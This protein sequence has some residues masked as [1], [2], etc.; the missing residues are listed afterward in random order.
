[1]PIPL[2][3]ILLL[4]SGRRGRFP[5]GRLA[6]LPVQAYLAR[7]LV[8]VQLRRRRARPPPR[9]TLLNRARQPLALHLTS[10]ISGGLMVHVPRARVRP[11]PSHPRA[12]RAPRS[13]PSPRPPCFGKIST[14]FS[15]DDLPLGNGMP[16]QPVGATAR[17][18]EGAGLPER[19]RIGRRVAKG[20][21][22][23]RGRRVHTTQGRQGR[24]KV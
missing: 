12:P 14:T 21:A 13:A 10:Q 8:L 22:D 18:A 9:K 6:T 5:L 3:L 7:A 4:S 15:R 23:V 24:P 20:F 11:P 2:R 17:S 16:D 19:R 1:M